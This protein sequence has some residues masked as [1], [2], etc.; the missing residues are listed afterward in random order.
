MQAS[1][2]AADHLLAG[3]TSVFR[4]SPPSRFP[5]SWAARYSQTIVLPVLA[6]SDLPQAENGMLDPTLTAF[7][8][9]PRESAAPPAH[10]GLAAQCQR[11]HGT[12]R[13]RNQGPSGDGPGHGCDSD[14]L[15]KVPLAVSFRTSAP[16]FFS[17]LLCLCR[18]STTHAADP[19]R[20]PVLVH[21]CSE[22]VWRAGVP[23]DSTLPSPT[24]PATRGSPAVL[25]ICSMRMTWETTRAKLHAS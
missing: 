7:L 1:G 6:P 24:P 5:Q 13:H 17:V 20:M 3:P 11:R 23:P 8:S 22:S 12:A 18:V 9:Q 16:L 2:A 14:H 15:R 4:S 25:P 10:L 19:R 21:R